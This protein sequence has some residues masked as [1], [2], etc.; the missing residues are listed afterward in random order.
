M[1]GDD[2]ERFETYL[3]LERFLAEL[4]AARQLIFRSL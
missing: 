3:E 2:Q 1:P 4:R